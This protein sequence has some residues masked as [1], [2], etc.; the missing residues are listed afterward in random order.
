MY[1]FTSKNQILGFTYDA[2]GN[3]A[4]DGTNSFTYDADGNVITAAGPGH[5]ATFTYDALNR[6]VKTVADGTAMEYVFNINGQRDSEWDP[7]THTQIKGHYYWGSSPVAFYTGSVGSGA[8]VHFEHQ[9]WLGT[10]RMR[11]ISGGSVEGTFTSLPFGDSFSVSGS[12]GDAYH[13]AALDHDATS[14][15]DHAR[16]RQYSEMSGRWMSPDPYSGSY[17]FT[18]PQSLNR[19]AYADNNPLSAVDPSGLM[20]CNDPY[21][22]YG[23]PSVGDGTGDDWGGFCFL[24]WCWGG[25]SGGSDAPAHAPQ[26]EFKGYKD[27]DPTKIMNEHLGLPPGMRLPTGGILDI[28]GVGFGD[29][30]EFGACGPGPSSFSPSSVGVSFSKI[31]IPP[32]VAF[33][34]GALAY[35]A[36]GRQG[37]LRG[38]W[39]YGN[40]CGQGGKGLPIN[41]VDTACMLHDYCYYQAGATALDNAWGH[42]AA[43]QACNQALCN[44]ARSFENQNLPISK[45]W[46]A[47]YQIDNF[48]TWGSTVGNSCKGFSF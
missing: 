9:D 47:A 1:S 39:R 16:F 3:L 24:F 2:A 27:L 46:W 20:M 42:S 30:C 48:F 31:K 18:D 6:R 7:A 15:T 4:S 37:P 5:S 41:G 11:T 43:V 35:G 19:Y 45:E 23:P 28:F 8:T 17:D 13:Y 34:F 29:G 21:C 40:F 36:S 44:S 10:E 14:T 25:G 26:P 33:F 22:V 32:E 12:D 38:P